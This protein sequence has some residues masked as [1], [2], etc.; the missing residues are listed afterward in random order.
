MELNEGVENAHLLEQSPSATSECSDGS[1]PTVVESPYPDYLHQH[2]GY[3]HLAD[4]TVHDRHLSPRESVP[5][6]EGLALE[7]DGFQHLDDNYT[8]LEDVTS[9]ERLPQAPDPNASIS[10]HDNYHNTQFFE[11]LKTRSNRYPVLARPDEKY[12]PISTSVPRLTPENGP[13][14]HITC[15]RNCWVSI[16]IV[17]AA[18]YA[19]AMS[20]FWFSV[21]IWR[22]NWGRLISTQSGITLANASV[23]CTLLAKSIEVSFVAVFVAF[24]GQRLSRKASFDRSKGISLA[25]IAMRTWVVQ[26]GSIVSHF[27][28]VKCA[29]LTYLGVMTLS[30]TVFAMLYTSASNALGRSRPSPYPFTCTSMVLDVEPIRILLIIVDFSIVSPRLLPSTFLQRTMHG[31]VGS[32]FAN[33]QYIKGQCQTPITT[34]LDPEYSGSTCNSIEQAGQGCVFLEHGENARH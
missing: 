27:E 26:P 23:T 10:R 25:E 9:K 34:H 12:N 15:N 1:V 8:N 22:P 18:F 5:G 14:N 24:L 7:F 16:G 2:L 6:I 17:I 32:S 13:V 31:N 30:V 28:L 19:T 11:P 33:V 29:G 4:A 3:A 21:A 20:G